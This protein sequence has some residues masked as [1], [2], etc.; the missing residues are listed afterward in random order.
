MA[1]RTPIGPILLVSPTGSLPPSVVSYLG[2]LSKATQG[3]V[4]G[5]QLA[6]P[7]AVVAALHAAVG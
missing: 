7:P 2:S 4:A 3:Y 1:T 6:V 5:G